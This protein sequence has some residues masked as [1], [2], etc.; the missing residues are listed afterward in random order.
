MEISDIIKIS[1]SLLILLIIIVSIVLYIKYRRKAAYI[2][3]NTEIVPYEGE[4]VGVEKHLATLKFIYK[5]DMIVRYAGTSKT[6][7]TLFDRNQSTKVLIN[8]QDGSLTL[9]FRKFPLDEYDIMTINTLPIIPFQ[10]RINLEI[11]MDLRNV[12][13]CIDGSSIHQETL[14]F[15]PFTGNTDVTLMPDGASHWIYIKMFDF[16]I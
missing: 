15:I 10:K 11:K 16:K 9:R 6:H 8:M 12:D 5:F 3:N 14:P 4:V 1:L 2:K 7:V 13:V